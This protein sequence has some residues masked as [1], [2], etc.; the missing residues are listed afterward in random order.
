MGFLDLFRRKKTNDAKVEKVVIEQEK[1]NETNAEGLVVGAMSPGKSL[2]SPRRKM[3]MTHNVG[4]GYYRPRSRRMTIRFGEGELNGI[5][6]S[7][8]TSPLPV[9]KDE[10]NEQTNEKVQ[11]EMNEQKN[12]LIL[13]SE[14]YYYDLSYLPGGFRGQV[15][16]RTQDS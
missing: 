16:T 3:S 7:P 9:E 10:K 15:R 12:E 5:I 6:T 1:K 13:K 11:N 8:R 4:D 2:K 14:L